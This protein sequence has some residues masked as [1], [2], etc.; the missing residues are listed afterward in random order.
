MITL[1]SPYQSENDEIGN[2]LEI[3][4]F[5]LK[6]ILTFSLKAEILVNPLACLLHAILPVHKVSGVGHSSPQ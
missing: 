3:Y 4:L 5:V 2:I 6:T 1:T